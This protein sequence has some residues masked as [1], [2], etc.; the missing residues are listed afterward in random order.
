MRTIRA[1]LAA[2]LSVSVAAVAGAAVAGAAAA[3]PVD[4]PVLIRGARVFDGRALLPA[5]ADVLLRD[6][7][8]AA[9]G[10]DAK[11]DDADAIDAT[12]KT[13]IPGLIDAHTH[14][15]APG[16]LRQAAAFGVT[17]ELDM[18]MPVSLARELRA[19][20][21]LGRADFRSAV[22]LAT[23]PGGHG[24]QYGVEIP[25]LTSPADAPAWVDG[26]IAEGAD[27][28]KIIYDD[29]SAAG[30]HFNKLSRQTMAAVVA[31]AHAK[32]KLAVAHVMDLASAREAIE[33]GVDGLAHVFV[34]APPDDAFCTLAK[35][36]KI[37]VTATI[38]VMEALGG[39][40][41]APSLAKDPRLA[42]M[43]SKEDAA[44]LRARFP[45]R[46]KGDE[47][48]RH[49]I[50]NVRRLHA[51]GVTILAGTD[52][53]NPGKLHGASLHRE[54][55]LL[56]QAGLTPTEALAAAT[57]APAESFRLADRGR[58]A[59]GMR[60]DL[61]LFDGD[62]TADILAT[63]AISR[64]W[65]AGRAFDRDGY[66]RQ[67]GQR[68]AALAKL[69][70]PGRLVVSD[71]ES[72]AI[73]STF[74]LGWSVSTDEIQRGKS[75][76]T[77]DLSDGGGANGSKHALRIKGAIAPPLPW[78]WSGAL[79]SPGTT[80]FGPADL[81]GKKK[82]VFWAKGDGKAARLM[83]FSQSTGYAPA[84]VVFTPDAQWKRFEFPLSDFRGCD[85]KDLTG[86]LFAGGVA[87]GP[88]E[89]QI[90]DVAFE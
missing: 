27:Y 55:E 18:F 63:R 79:F 62:P 28:I 14:I 17:T 84:F 15:L 74:G 29:G 23:A 65:I 26:R 76:A 32:G 56:V 45:R 90:D 51:A 60:A 9:V 54:L 50:E 47:A 5:P 81:S 68:D 57:A 71:F 87:H 10:P 21:D 12:G 69:A 8:I 40:E 82:I 3:E 1:L 72:D 78:A 7:K 36:H 48:V 13:L 83:V 52:A 33:A 58:I 35:D 25:T 66:R 85:G 64:T 16:V 46:A 11:A 75:T 89:Y 2:V 24:T 80:P 44:A 67:I 77:I 73:T 41:D 61:A 53:P 49:A 6:G 20:Q 4:R 42:P 70:E 37:W 88:F 39:G 31:A 34:D 59:P 30:V 19:K 86:L 43:L 22:T 38:T